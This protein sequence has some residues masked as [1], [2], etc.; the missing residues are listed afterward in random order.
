MFMSVLARNIEQRKRDLGISKSIDLAKKSG[1]SRAVLTNI[2]VN[3]EKSIMLDSAVRLAEAL[4]CRL[5]WLA[6]GKGEPNLDEYK[7]AS[8]I[9]LGAPLVTLNELVGAEPK[10][11]IER[12][13]ELDRERHPCPTGNSKT[14][15]IIKSNRKIL[16]YP[17][18][19]FYFDVDKTPVSGQLVIADTGGNAEIMEYQST[20]GRQ[21]LKSLEEDLPKELRFVEITE[22]K[23]LGTFEAFAIF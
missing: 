19:Y 17:A 13:R 14:Q 3:P 2:K 16:D 23:L 20:Y 11:L 10:E 15:I 9:D 7:E 5:E 18:G 12:V 6:T 21:F 4:D 22:Q 8:K 1:V